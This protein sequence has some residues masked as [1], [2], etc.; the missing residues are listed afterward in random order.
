MRTSHRS[1]LL[2]LLLCSGV[3]AQSPDFTFQLPS[4]NGDERV[5]LTVVFDADV[6]TA[7]SWAMGLCTDYSLAIPID[8]Q[9]GASMLA[10][11]P[12]V[13]VYEIVTQGVRAFALLSLL[14]GTTLPVGSGYEVV[15]VEY[16][17][18]G[19]VGDV[20]DVS[21]CSWV[22]PPGTPTQVSTG[23]GPVTP[24][25]VDGSITIIAQDPNPAT[26]P[27]GGLAGP[28]PG[29]GDVVFSV[30]SIEAFEQGTVSVAL[31]NSHPTLSGWSMS[32]CSDSTLM[33]P[34]AVDYTGLLADVAFL[35]VQIWE[36]GV[37][38]LCIRDFMT[39]E[40]WPVVSGQ[41]LFNV[42]YSLVGPVGALAPITFCNTLFDPPIETVATSEWVTVV[43]DTIDGS[44]LIEATDPSPPPPPP[45]STGGGGPLPDDEFEFRAGDYTVDPTSGQ[46]DFSIFPVIAGQQTSDAPTVAFS[47]SI[48]Y[49]SSLIECVGGDAIGE[50]AALGGTGPAYFDV[51][52]SVGQVDVGVV[53]DFVG[54]L[55]I[56]IGPQGEALV[57]LDFQTTALASLGTDTPLTWNPVEPANVVIQTIPDQVFPELVN[58]LVTFDVVSLTEFFRGEIN[59]DGNY[60]LAD[61]VYL[62]THLF[63]T[64]Q[65]ITCVAAADGNGDGGLDISDP[66]Y[67]LSHLFS[68][69]SA[70][71]APY[72]DCGVDPVTTLSCV[73]FSACP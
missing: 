27:G 4:V 45:P 36:D 66:V 41:E 25:T 47:M 28:L 9:R 48:Q 3:N 51:I 10:I 8:V 23:G 58:G 31:D 29:P 61:T 14:G 44:I 5:T 12:E 49:D 42:T 13:E 35:D 17:L 55:S 7:Q 56:P 26:A 33:Y 69:G 6:P 52:Q 60:D 32:L 22:T 18:V 1:L 21:F 2:L 54:A 71:A 11:S 37:T 24:T 16:S 68:F 50:L 65:P 43:P 38:A 63:D 40:S 62:L 39:V 70:P 67:F 53:Y 30:E 34:I 64:A 73:S 20:V 46:T 19:P 57:R 72:P 59:G 15:D